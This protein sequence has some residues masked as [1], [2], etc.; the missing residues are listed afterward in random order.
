[1]QLSNSY[2]FPK[3]SCKP[4]E[5]SIACLIFFVLAAPIY[6]S[7]DYLK[8]DFRSAGKIKKWVHGSICNMYYTAHAQ[9]STWTCT[10]SSSILKAEL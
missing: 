9:D 10:Y 1:M 3:L 2:L 6:E 5:N 8:D 7:N 4:S